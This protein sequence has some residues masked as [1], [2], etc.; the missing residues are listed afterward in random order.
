MLWVFWKD[1]VS[2][3]KREDEEAAPGSAAD[4]M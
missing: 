4:M 2:H 1:R 3:A